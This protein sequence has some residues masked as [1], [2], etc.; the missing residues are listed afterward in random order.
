[1]TQYEMKQRSQ[2]CLEV[3]PLISQRNVQ[4]RTSRAFM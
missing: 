4:A 3:I 1:M 2:R